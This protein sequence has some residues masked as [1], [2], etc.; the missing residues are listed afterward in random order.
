M[1]NCRLHVSDG[2]NGANE[3]T[4]NRKK[5]ILTLLA[6][7]RT[8]RDLGYRFRRERMSITDQAIDQ[9]ISFGKDYAFMKAKDHFGFEMNLPS[10]NENNK[11]YSEFLKWLAQYDKNLSH[12]IT[13]KNNEYETLGNVMFV[14]HLDIGTYLLVRAGSNYIRSRSYSEILS[15]RENESSSEGYLYFFGK[16]SKKYYDQV[17]KI[18]DTSPEEGV[19]YHMKVSAGADNE[20]FKIN[21]TELKQRR[22]NTIFLENNVIDK[23]KDHIDRFIDNKEIYKSRDLRYKTGL[24]LKGEPGT[25]KTSLATA[26]ATEYHTDLISIDMT[27]FA[28]INTEFLSDTINGDDDQYTILLE[29]IDCIVGDRESEETDKE[30]KQVINKLLQFLDSATSPSNVIFIAT[31]NHPEKLDK[32]LTRSGR[33]DLS[34]EIK[35]I[36]FDK[37]VEMCKSFD[38][39]DKV[40]E[41]IHQEIEEGPGYP[42][43]QSW[44]QNRI[45]ESIGSKETEEVIA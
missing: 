29:D 11:G 41:E 4:S 42:V 38:M 20:N 33:F 34:V 15:R 25:G 40:I 10:A 1:A 28:G 32:A 44:L 7:S 31:T 14:C 39:N 26:I 23:V 16:K 5:G 13:K 24:L 27:S 18:F 21:S 37:M 45:L 3:E 8:G 43:N 35:G 22:F 17:T 12:H 6:N 2:P 9:V 19:L 36:F 30:D